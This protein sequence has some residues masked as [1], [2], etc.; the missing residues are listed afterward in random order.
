MTYLTT[1]TRMKSMLN[2]T[3]NKT[4]ISTTQCPIREEAPLKVN[5]EIFQDFGFPEFYPPPV[6]AQ[7]LCVRS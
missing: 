2:L 6:L 5:N 3:N 4:N 1:L 7:D